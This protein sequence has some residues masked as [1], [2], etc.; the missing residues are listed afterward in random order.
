MNIN[1][2]YKMSAKL[3]CKLATHYTIFP[4]KF[5]K[6]IQTQGQA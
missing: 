2:A 4:F 5:T 6:I 3:K 1:L